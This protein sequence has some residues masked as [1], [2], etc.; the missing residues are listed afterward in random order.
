MLLSHTCA[1]RT[2][3]KDSFSDSFVRMRLILLIFFVDGRAPQLDAVEH[4][5]DHDLF[6]DARVAEEL[7]GDGN[8][9]LAVEVAV[10]SPLEQSSTKESVLRVQEGKSSDVF[11]KFVPLV[12]RVHIEAMF[13]ASSN[14]EVSFGIR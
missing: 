8:A 5:E 4:A 14:D 3:F 11:L 7:L 1:L 9:G 10:G 12:L 6:F 13:E 2:L